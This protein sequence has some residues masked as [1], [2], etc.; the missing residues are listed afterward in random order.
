VDQT[1]NIPRILVVPKGEVTSGF[2]AFKLSTT[3]IN[4]QPVER[5]ILIQYLVDHRQETLAS[6]GSGQTELRLEDYLVRA[7]VDF[8]DVS[9]DNHADLLYDLAGQTVA[10]LKSYLKDAG[11]VANVLQYYHRQVAG[12]IH[13]QMQEHHWE[14][15]AGLDVIVSKGFTSLKPLAFTAPA[16]APVYDFRAP[17]ADK[18]KIAQ[19]IF[20]GFKK[21][22]YPVQKFQ[23]DTERVLSVILDRAGDKWFKPGKGQ[24]QI[25]YKWVADQREYQPDFVV[26]TPKCIYML[27]PKARNDMQDPEV[28]AK[29][30][31]AV[32]WCR[33]A[34][35]H[36]AKNSGKPWKYLLIPH[37]AIAENMSISG[38]GAQFA[39]A[40]G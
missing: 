38:L 14:K 13:A 40:P 36:A 9:Y 8:D 11:E 17:V 18:T 26:E 27:E 3:N 15:V 12:L 10:H 30:D 34:T 1:I 31:S 24:F 25:F 5:D 22:L 2:T 4:Y 16:G 19:M 7:L 21:C 20:G 33:H 28:M 6:A 29:K 37:D 39:V 32:R 23:S 35:E